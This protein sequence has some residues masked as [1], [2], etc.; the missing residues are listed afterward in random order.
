MYTDKAKRLQLW[1]FLPCPEDPGWAPKKIA[2]SER[3]QIRD[4]WK[5][6]NFGTKDQAWSLKSFC[7]AVFY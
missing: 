7:V 1:V 5:R 6:F 4:L 2:Y 3:C